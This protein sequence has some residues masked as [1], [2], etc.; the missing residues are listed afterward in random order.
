MIFYLFDF[1]V[2]NLNVFLCVT[3]L[4]RLGKYTRKEFIFLLF[5]DIFIN[6]IPVVFISIFLLD[7]LNKIIR[8]KLVNSFILDN[9][10]FLGNYIFFFLVIFIFKNKS[11]IV[12]DLFEFYLN[13]FLMNYIFFLLFYKNLLKN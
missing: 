8:K 12:N 7:W 3:I 6:S 1:F 10:L 2:N 13:N 11:F 5:V 4:F 9:L